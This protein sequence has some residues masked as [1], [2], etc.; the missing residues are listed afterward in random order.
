MRSACADRYAIHS[1]ACAPSRVFGL[2]S[3][4]SSSETLK[5][6][7]LQFSRS[8]TNRHPVESSQLASDLAADNGTEQLPVFSLET[9]HLALFDGIE[10]GGAGVDLD[11]GQQACG[12]EI[13]QARRLFHH[14]SA[15]EIVAA[16][17]Q[18]LDHRLREGVSGQCQ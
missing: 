16:L 3:S 5:I 11:A 14:I 18:H 4:G 17:L 12:L 10:V 1:P 9:H 2:C 7:R 13:L 15:G 6:R 8:E